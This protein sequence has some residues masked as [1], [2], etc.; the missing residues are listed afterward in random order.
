MQVLQEAAGTNGCV[1]EVTVRLADSFDASNTAYEL[2]AYDVTGSPGTQPVRMALRA[3]RTLHVDPA[4]AGVAQTV[5]LAPCL[6]VSAGQHVA[7]ASPTGRLGVTVVPNQ[8]SPRAYWN[9]FTATASDLGSEQSMDS[10]FVGDLGW[11]A[12]LV[13][14]ACGTATTAPPEDDH[15]AD[16]S[17]SATRLE[18]DEDDKEEGELSVNADDGPADAGV[19][20]EDGHPVDADPAPQDQD[21]SPDADAGVPC[22]TLEQCKRARG[23]FA[24]TCDDP[25]LQVAPCIN[26]RL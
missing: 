18:E 24:W 12:V 23:P 15:P 19:A 11:R 6:P 10:Q 14:A 7:L 8:A 4:R 25:R 5:A 21:P 22:Q 13:P 9:I 2:R 20:P 3:K 17:A 26:N 16:A 1:G